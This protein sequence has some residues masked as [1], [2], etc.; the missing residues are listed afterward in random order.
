VAGITPSAARVLEDRQDLGTRILQP[1]ARGIPARAASG[2]RP[3][4]DSN[5]SG[6]KAR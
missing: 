5:A 3:N 1:R 2:Q 4:P 6:T